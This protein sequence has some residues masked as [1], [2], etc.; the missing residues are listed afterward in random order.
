MQ[1]AIAANGPGL[2]TTLISGLPQTQ[3]VDVNL[4]ALMT[5]QA[6][7]TL[8][9]ALPLTHMATPALRIRIR[10]APL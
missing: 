9:I 1:D 3:N 4:V 10:I 5:L 8:L 7:M 6:A 2:P